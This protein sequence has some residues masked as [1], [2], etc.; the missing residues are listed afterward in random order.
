M[1]ITEEQ[2]QQ[3]IVIARKIISSAFGKK[4]INIPAELQN[5]LIEKRGV[6]VTLNKNKELRG[7]IGFPEPVFP[8]G[9]AL[10]RAARGA[11]FEDSRFPPLKKEELDEIKI[12]ISILTPSKKI[13]A[14]PKEINISKDGLIVKQGAAS[15]LLLPQVAEEHNWTAEQFL[16]QTCIKASLPPEAWKNNNSEIYKFQAQIFKE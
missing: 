14:N 11:A 7:C 13:Q 12:E 3:L 15:G 9:V 1:N 8:L 2:G 10:A 5:L 4:E 6:F 16:N